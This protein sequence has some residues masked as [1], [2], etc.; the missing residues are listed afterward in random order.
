MPPRL[1]V[2]MSAYACEP[3]RG[4]EPEVG[5][6]WALQMAR[7]HDVTVVTR[8]NNQPPIE[9]A[10]SSYPGPKPDFIYYDL[11]DWLLGLKRRGLPV[12]V[13]YALWQGSVRRHLARRLPNFDLIH[14][15]T[16]NS[17]RQ[18]GFWWSC[19]K[20]VVLGPLGGGQICPWR[21]LPTF[22]RRLLPEAARSLSVVG[23]ALLPNLYA[24]FAAAT[25][26]LVANR[27]TARRIHAAS[28]SKIQSLLETGVPRELIQS[29]GARADDGHVRIIWVSRLEKIKG[30]SLALRAF[31][32]AFAREKQ[33]RL[34]I[35]GGGPESARLR[36]L[37]VTLGIDAAITW[38]GAV[39]KADI[40]KLLRSHDVFLFTSLRDTSGNVLLE[41][42]A[43]GLPAL[44]LLHHGA[45]EIATD[46]T[47][48][49]IPP[50]HPAETAQAIA[51]G[52][53]RLA[54]APDLR[55][56]MSRAAT[57]R[58]LAE[59]SWEQ[60]GAQMSAIYE[61]AVRQYQAR[62]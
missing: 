32:L 22:G 38:H 25:V 21:F 40:P 31:A 48:L 7:F 35:V 2:L 26:I 33:L 57:A 4:S 14:H 37:A 28:R 24:S 12:P 23:S 15:V 9:S 39:P 47:A 43:T 59:F 55:E 44:T 61:R 60:K 42:M 27:D 41:A 10:L 50:T 54:N 45:A 30:G 52:I 19:G 36:R 53:L 62:P 3:H 58:L 34:S 18:P 49:R 20:P 6:Q 1:K 51:R 56:R 13:Y 46:E 5:W 17:F 29:A 8:A 16:F 11:P